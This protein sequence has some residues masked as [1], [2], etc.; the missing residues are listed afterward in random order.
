MSDQILGDL[1]TQLP[2]DETIPTH[3][4]IRIVDALFKQKKGIFDRIFE[5]MKDILIMG[6]LFVF[7]SLSFTDDLIKK[8]IPS[9]QTSQYILLLIKTCLFMFVFFLIKNFYLSRKN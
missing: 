4:E 5:S 9:S 2:I 1:I 8:Y 7:F 6:I 3:D